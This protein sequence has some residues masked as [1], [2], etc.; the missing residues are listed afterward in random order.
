VTVGGFELADIAKSG[1][2]FAWSTTCRGWTVLPREGAGLDARRLREETNQG[3]LSAMRSSSW[4]ACSNSGPRNSRR[5]TPASCRDPCASSRRSWFPLVVRCE[6]RDRSHTAVSRTQN[7]LICARPPSAPSAPARHT[8]WAGLRSLSAREIPARSPSVAIAGQARSHGSG[9]CHVGAH[10]L[11]TGR[12]AWR[13][14][15]GRGSA[16]KVSD[17]A[18]PRLSSRAARLVDNVVSY[19][20]AMVRAVARRTGTA[21]RWRNETC[22]HSG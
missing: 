19:P 11:V 14:R 21:A 8:E 5:T 20:Q 9:C 13:C 16:G 7:C 3:R 12:Q 10:D 4:P 2:W 1:R 22:H 15:A 6:S 17:A 18:G